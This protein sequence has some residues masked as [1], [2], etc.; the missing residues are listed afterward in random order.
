MKVSLSWLQDFVDLSGIDPVELADRLT[1]SGLEV[2]AVHV[3]QKVEGVV[4]AYVEHAEKH[5]DADKLS[6]CRVRDGEEVLQ[7]VCGAPNVRTGLTIAFARVGAKL[8]GG[9]AIKKAKIRGTESFGM[10][11][12]ESELGIS[13]ESN[14]IMELPEGTPLGV[15]VNELLGLGDS[16][17]EIS[18][19]PNRSDCLSMVGVARD[20]AALYGRTLKQETFKA[21]ETGGA[22]SALSSVTVLDKEKCPMYFGRIIKGVTVQP[23]PF[24]M[25]NRLRAVGVRPINNVVDV[26]NYVLYSFGQPLHTFDLRMVEGGIIVRNAEE[27]EKIQ[28]LDGKER[29][30]NSNMLVIADT[31]KVLAVAGVMGGEHSGIMPDTTDV[32]LECACFKPE[33]IRM[34]ARRLGMSSDSSYRYERGIDAGNTPNMVEYAAN[35]I[36]QVAGGTILSGV[37]NDAWTPAVPCTVTASVSWINSFLGTKIS[38]EEM[39]DILVRLGMGVA[40]A[41]DELLVTVPTARVDIERQVDIAE[42]VARVYGY[43]NIE[44]SVPVIEADGQRMHPLLRERMLL[45]QSLMGF[46]FNEAVNYSF[47]N[48]DYLS[49]FD[50]K[51]RFVYL[52]NPLSEDWNALRTMVF[53]GVISTLKTNWNQGFRNLRVFEFATSFVKSGNQLPYEEQRLSLGLMGDFWPLSWAGKDNGV[54]PFYF[55]KGVVENITS[56]YKLSVTF[57]RSKR[58]FMHPGKSA[59]VML[60]GVSIGFFGELHPELQEKADL[61]EKAYIA[62]LFFERMVEACTF[63]FRYSKF[64]RFPFVYK[65]ISLLVPKTADAAELRKEAV[66]VSPLIDDVVLFDVYSGKGIDEGERSLTYRIW[67]SDATKTLTD[68]ETN[69]VTAEVVAKLGAAFGARLR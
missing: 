38:R 19:T 35:L 58:H 32:F 22:A 49:M 67:F 29:S 3:G 41:G 53:P 60:N 39:V 33:S 8:P 68:E 4:T 50:E 15:D 25:Q 46:G 21:A 52:M 17:L 56:R 20:I 64:S 65:D 2:E 10:I 12:S 48:D 24:W 47:M 5:P 44:T 43:N 69:G 57:E 61:K 26:T 16:T 30:L 54:D 27:G 63:G 6:L 45:S 36:Q 66:A 42:E 37:L 40:G 9:F 31:K 11:C 34:T 14:G 51:E 62:E 13:E 23:S 59:E 18:I 55:L 7:V 1:M 28:T